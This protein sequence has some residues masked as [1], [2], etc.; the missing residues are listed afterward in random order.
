MI[1]YGKQ[2]LDAEDIQAVVDVLKSDWLTTGPKV[3]EF[4]KA[5]AAFT[6]TKEAVAVSNGTAALHAAVYAAGIGP[7]D[8]V[9]VT[10]MSFAA[11]ANCAVFQGATPVFADVREE[12][13]LIDPGK[14]ERAITGKT[15]AI[16]AVDYAG[17]PC[18]YDS[19]TALARARGL[20]LIA[21]ACH[22]VGGAYKGR[23]V[24]SLADLSTFSFHPVKNMT[25]GE[26]GA[27][28]TDNEEYARRMRMFRSHGVTVDFR[29][30]MESHSWFYEM[31]DLG[32]N[33]RITDFQCALGI[34]Q[35]KKLPG[36]ITRR[37]EIAARY[38]AA[39]LPL[40]PVVR[41]VHPSSLILHPASVHG[42]HLYVI[43]VPAARRAEIFG[44]LR[45]QG[46]G[47]NVHY[48]PIHLHPFYRRRFGTGPGLCPAAERAYE[49]L[50]SLPMYPAMT[51]GEVA[52]VI[53][54]VRHALGG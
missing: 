26:G 50:I 18:D 5:L 12:D 39:F 10:P 44:A 41:P 17:L 54:G 32:W 37:N 29:Q 24:G 19:L 21:D 51:D 25:T 42:R 36:W 49:E 23:P 33:Y 7:G 14:V 47:V 4:E 2:F 20:V 13:L 11:S 16:I 40:A 30:R 52:A 45:K 35:L 8:E 28:T 46:I 27:I 31:V 15:K 22:A 1:P 34:T 3:A 9:I 38:D 48:I 43:R 53:G 6:G